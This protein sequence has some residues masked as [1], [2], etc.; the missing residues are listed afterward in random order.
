MN[1]KWKLT[2]VIC[3]RRTFSVHQALNNI[4]GHGGRGMAAVETGSTVFVVCVSLIHSLV[5]NPCKYRG[6]FMFSIVE[7]IFKFVMSL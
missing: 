3:K 7:L 5:W 2:A 1:R 4:N 6:T